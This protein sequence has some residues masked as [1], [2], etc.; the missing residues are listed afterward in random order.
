MLR[1]ASPSQIRY[2]LNRLT[3]HV[4]GK[5]A[6]DCNA[7][8]LSKIPKFLRCATL[9]G[10]Q[11]EEDGIQL[12]AFLP[13]L[14]HLVLK[15]KKLLVFKKDLSAFDSYMNFGDKLGLRGVKYQKLRRK[16]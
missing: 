15:W 12:L 5:G 10:P 7:W 11:E 2:D 16:A 8:N 4:F 9:I 13:K 14:G 3:V 6:Q 1:T